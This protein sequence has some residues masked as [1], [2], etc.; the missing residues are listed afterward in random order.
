VVVW[1]LVGGLACIGIVYLLF[2]V[3]DTF[4]ILPG[5]PALS[6]AWRLIISA[7]VGL[8]LAIFLMVSITNQKEQWLRQAEQLA[9]NG[10]Q[11]RAARMV[12][13]ATDLDLEDC[14]RVIET[15][16][17][18]RSAAAAPPDLPEEV[19]RLADAGEQLRAVERLRELTG[20]DLAEA[21]RLVEQYL[22]VRSWWQ[23]LADDPA[24]KIEA[25]RAYRE[26]HG[27]GLAEA[28]HAVEEYIRERGRARHE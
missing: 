28:I 9:A 16:L 7:V 17:A 27:A 26:E 23:E 8:A 11:I 20:M 13:R 3:A 14:V 25:I 21:M 2:W 6:P 5:P 19:R 1:S 24:Q 10:E 15:F 12:R 18:S 22:G 4:P